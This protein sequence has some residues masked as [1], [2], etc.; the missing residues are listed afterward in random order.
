[1]FYS[2]K[3]VDLFNF[4]DESPIETAGG[5]NLRETQLEAACTSVFDSE[6]VPHIQPNPEYDFIIESV[7]QFPEC[8]MRLVSAES[9]LT[10]FISSQC[11]FLQ[12]AST[13]P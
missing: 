6:A 4:F 5:L 11:L 2:V 10:S 8:M 1:M 3:K 13:Q 12:D 7:S 9:A